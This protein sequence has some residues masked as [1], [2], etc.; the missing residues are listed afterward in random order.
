MLLSDVAV[1]VLCLL[2]FRPVCCYSRWM[3]RVLGE[4]FM[5]N[6]PQRTE[7]AA[8]EGPGPGLV[9]CLVS[10]CHTLNS[11]LSAFPRPCCKFHRVKVQLRWEMEKTK[12]TSSPVRLTGNDV[13]LPPA[14]GLSCQCLYRE[15]LLPYIYLVKELNSLVLNTT[16]REAGKQSGRQAGNQHDNF[17]SSLF[18]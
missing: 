14:S 13:S 10:K 17:W 4:L 1:I 2:S 5:H 11:A 15:Q 18:F 3:A 6:N 16:K 7:T 9:S 8:S 12:A